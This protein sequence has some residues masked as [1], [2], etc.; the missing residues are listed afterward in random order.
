MTTREEIKAWLKSSGTSRASL[1]ECLGVS[2]G[3]VNNWLAGAD[4]IPK[5][6]LAFIENIMRFGVAQPNITA[7]KAFAV[8]LPDEDYGKCKMA[9]AQAGK[10]LEEWAAQVL[11]IAAFEQPSIHK[12]KDEPS[13]DT[14]W[15]AADSE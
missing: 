10:P 14:A 4:P 3:T 11:T 1:A 9:A 12:Y 5:I 8:Q 15:E 7:L 2:K 6:K 13:E